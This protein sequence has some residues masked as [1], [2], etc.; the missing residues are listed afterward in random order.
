MYTFIGMLRILTLVGFLVVLAYTTETRTGASV[1]PQDVYVTMLASDFEQT[2]A[3]LIQ[4][5]LT[6][7][8]IRTKYSFPEECLI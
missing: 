6:T 4:I 2:N 3:E 7:G 1:K 5:D 8:D